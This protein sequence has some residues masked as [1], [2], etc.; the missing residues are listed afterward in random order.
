MRLL[1]EHEKKV[2]AL[3]QALAEGE[4]SGDAIVFSMDNILAEAR[5]DA[6]GRLRDA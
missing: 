2:M 3:N 5:Q 1:E 6:Q 4:A